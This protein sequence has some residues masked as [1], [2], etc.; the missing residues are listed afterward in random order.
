MVLRPMVIHRLKKK[1]TLRNSLVVLWLR[2]QAPKAG[3][4]GSI[5]GWG[6]IRKL[7]AHLPH[8]AWPKT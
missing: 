7:R 4:T 2:R 8:K 1:L 6:T 3:G 5:L